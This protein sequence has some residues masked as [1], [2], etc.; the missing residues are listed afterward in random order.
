L[1]KDLQHEQETVQQLNEITTNLTEKNKRVT[2]N[3]KDTNEELQNE[4]QK[5]KQLQ[6]DLTILKKNVIK[7]NI[8][9]FI[10]YNFLF[11]YVIIN[12]L[13]L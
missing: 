4:F 10:Y 8:L 6:E 3:L 11:I 9:L 2:Q 13:L 5:N 7:I 1:K 12:K